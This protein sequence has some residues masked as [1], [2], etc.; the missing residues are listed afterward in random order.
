MK[1]TFLPLPICLGLSAAVLLSSCGKRPSEAAPEQKLPTATVRVQVVESLK[2][3]ATEEVVGTVR[4]KLSASL[5]AKVS[6]TIGQML[7][8]PGQS[9]KAGQ[10]LVE[11][12][13]REVQARL[14]QAQ[15]VREQTGKDIE[16][17]KKL[18]AQN[19]VTQQEFDGVQSRFRVAEATVKE[20]EAM[21]GYTK[22][23]APFDGIVI[24][25][26]ADVGDLAAPGKPL[27]EL[28]DPTALRLEADV[29]EAL[30]DRI[31]LNDKLGVLVPSASLSLEAT[32]SEISPAADPVSR[33]SRVKL[34][35]PAVQG[36]RSGQ[37]GRVAVPVAEV[38]ALRVPASAV[39]VRGQMEIGFVL[40][41]QQAQLR[42]VK[43][44]KHLGQE[45]EIV[46]GLN[47]G[48]ELVVEGATQLLDGQP[49]EVKR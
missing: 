28:E 41:N 10:L 24:A 3:T 43:T 35:L 4:P 33:T 13:A 27:L 30:L 8:T 37:F 22:V 11:I 5:S 18:L 29:P 40:V 15:A 20:A 49:V 6:G 45:V 32:V 25:K 38:I 39:V 23:I 12:D 42:L 46:S 14:D 34:D 47:S 16:R 19:A 1:N 2:R 31:K 36:L 48:E 7:A 44:G 9:V 26:R 21:L 17:F